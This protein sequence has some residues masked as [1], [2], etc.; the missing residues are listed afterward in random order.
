MLSTTSYNTDALKGNVT[1][2][3]HFSFCVYLEDFVW[4]EVIFYERFSNT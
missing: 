2:Q 1:L 3:N 4:L